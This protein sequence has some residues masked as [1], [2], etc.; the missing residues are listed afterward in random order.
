MHVIDVLF[1]N[2]AITDFTVTIT[3]M[4]KMNLPFVHYNKGFRLQRQELQ[5]CQEP[6]HLYGNFTGCLRTPLRLFGCHW[7]RTFHSYGHG[8]RDPLRVVVVTSGGTNDVHAPFCGDLSGRGA[9]FLKR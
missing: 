3:I 1:N 4:V 7:M 5:L 8:E 6:E 9:L 2:D